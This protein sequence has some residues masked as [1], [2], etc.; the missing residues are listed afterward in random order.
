MMNMKQKYQTYW[1]FSGPRQFGDDLI[2][3]VDPR[4]GTNEEN[5]SRSTTG[6]KNTSQ[7]NNYKQRL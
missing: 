3:S 7:G 2:A 1:I 6:P 4:D 5:Q